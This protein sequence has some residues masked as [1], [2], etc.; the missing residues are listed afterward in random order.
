[1]RKILGLEIGTASIGWAYVQEAE[2]STENSSIIGCGVRIVPHA[3]GEEGAFT[4]GVEFSLNAQRSLKR[5]ARRGLQRFKLRRAALLE[6]L[7]Q[8]DI[9]PMDFD[10][11]E[12]GKSSTFS[13]YRLRAKAAVEQVSKKELAQVLLMLNKKRGYKRNRKFK[14][15]DQAAGLDAVTT[16][17]AVFE[18]NFTPGQRGFQRLEQGLRLNADFY[19]SELQKELQAIVHFQNQFFPKDFNSMLLQTIEGKSAEQTYDYFSKIM[20]IEPAANAA[21]N[22]EMELQEYSWRNEALINRLEKG[23]LAYIIIEINRHINASSLYMGDISERSRAL[24]LNG[25]T[26]GQFQ[27]GLIEKNHHARLKNQIFL[28]QNCIDEFEKIWQTQSRF[29]PELNEQLKGRIKDGIIFYQRGAESQKHLVQHC[30]FEK[31]HKAVPKSSPLFQEFK[32]RQDLNR[33]TLRNTETEQTVILS[34]QLRDKIAGELQFK[35]SMTS[36]QLLSLCRLDSRYHS[37]DFK[38]IQGNATNIEFYRAFEKILIHEG[39]DALDLAAS[40]PDQI[41]KMVRDAFSDL[42]INT[43]VLDFDAAVPGN[44][45]DKQPFYQ[46]WHLLYSSEDETALK[47]KLMQK[48]GFRENHLP[49]L[50][51]ISLKKNYGSLSARAVRKLL[52]KMVCG[53]SYENACSAVGYIQPH[54]PAAVGRKSGDQKNSLQLLG[55]N[56]LRSP[57]AEKVC[58]QMINVVNAVLDDHAMGRPDEIRI[59]LAPELKRTREQRRRMAAALHKNA[60]EGRKIVKLLQKEFALQRVT[61][62]DIIR[63]RLWQECGGISIYTGEDIPLQRLFSEEYLIGHIIP[64]TLLF[65]ESFSNLILCES[66]LDWEK[67]DKTAY[68]YLKEKLPAEEFV[69]FQK[70][71]KGLSGKISGAKQE[72]LLSTSREIEKDSLGRQLAERQYI[73]RSIKDLLLQVCTDVAFTAQAVTMKLIKDWKLADALQQINWSTYHQRGLTYIEKGKNGES[74]QRI[75]DWLPAHD[76]RQQALKAIA[77]AF[78]RPLY[79]EYL[80][81]LNENSGSISQRDAGFLKTDRSGVLRLADPMPDFREQVIGRLENILIS[82][83]SKSKAAVRN[84]NRTKKAGGSSLTMQLTPRGPLHKETVYAKTQHYS[85]KQHKVGAALTP[86]LIYRTA[87][88]PYRE[89]LL[90]R[91]SEHGNDPKKAFAG[92]NSPAKK[93]IFLDAQKTLCVPEKVRLVWLEPRYTVRKEITPDLKL[94]KITDSG[95]RKLLENRLSE[96]QGDPKKA[97]LDLEHRP[98]WQNKE[99]GIAVKRVTLTGVSNAVALHHKKDHLGNLILD[100]RLQ[101]VPSDFV[102]TGHNHHAAVYRDENGGMQDEVVSFY[103]AVK[104]SSEGLPVIKSSHEKGWQLLFSMRQNDLFLFPEEGSTVQHNVLDLDYR[105]L[106]KRLYRL[107]KFSKV[108]YGNAFRRDYVFRHHTQASASDAKELQGAAYKSVK[109]LADLRGIVKVRLDHLGR[110]AGLGEF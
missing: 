20:K 22:R 49:F 37:A 95:I 108:P 109:S 47:K 68:S 65:D 78:T 56:S 52:P 40:S 60:A 42:K 24:Y 8:A 88:K 12:R 93:P 67:G 55:K 76:H 89:A 103:E 100:D 51:N 107:Q 45:F 101:A 39:Y 7:A 35:E 19:S 43:R 46:L 92:E 48:F 11:A 58:S 33:I 90:K 15:D 69:R 13:S 72:K 4:S 17:T 75:K 91:L 27:F 1:M 31:G 64:R 87:D 61:R 79:L 106:G 80:N 59:A 71:V 85:V 99:Q 21:N 32:I 84:K 44:G 110:I 36:R 86:E 23:V 81:R 104:R 5:R 16:S 30:E 50:L 98:I 2:N 6:A 34:R 105:E 25:Q 62:N 73:A 94:E 63:Y 83:S 54:F 3:P 96:S 38:K 74:L 82:Y 28:R 18:N 53:Y 57:A 70:R 102:S 10:Y 66:R 9:I 41:H 26:V 97:F 77:A 14:E 29:H